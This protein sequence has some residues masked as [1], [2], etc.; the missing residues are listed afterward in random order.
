MW[1][2]F[3]GCGSPQ[4]GVRDV[5]SYP[6]MRSWNTRNRGVSINFS[7]KAQNDCLAALFSVLFHHFVVPESTH[8]PEN[9]GFTALLFSDLWWFQT[10]IL[11]DFYDKIEVTR[12]LNW[13]MH[14]WQWLRVNSTYWIQNWHDRSSAHVLALCKTLLKADIFLWSLCLCYVRCILRKLQ[15]IQENRAIFLQR[16]KPIDY[17]IRFRSYS[18]TLYRGGGG[19]CTPLKNWNQRFS[20]W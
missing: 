18:I 9:M 14:R 20:M 4:L 2:F 15:E 12:T 5:Q 16:P 6:K 1:F 13:W 17:L 3:P 10:A 8:W 19:N 11:W 7:T